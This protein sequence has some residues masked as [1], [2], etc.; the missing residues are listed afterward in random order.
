MGR[1]R[2][3]SQPSQVTCI[4]YAAQLHAIL[5][6]I[7]TPLPGKR[8]GEHSVDA[9]DGGVA[10]PGGGAAAA[11]RR[12]RY[13][14]CAL[15]CLIEAAGKFETAASPVRWGWCRCAHCCVSCTFHA[16]LFER[17][18][19]V[20]CSSP[21]SGSA[22]LLIPVRWGWCRCSHCCMSSKSYILSLCLMACWGAMSP[23]VAGV[24][25]LQKI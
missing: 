3:T 18:C 17:L 10:G 19:Q 7:L 22:S 5:G 12:E 20:G 14:L 9:A 1:S 16:E 11:E 24:S 25:N 2:F 8:S 15:Q 13:M 23:K 6:R 21:Q 4:F